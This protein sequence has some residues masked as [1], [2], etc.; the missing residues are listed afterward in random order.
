MYRGRRDVTLGGE[1]VEPGLGG[2]HGLVVGK[3]RIVVGQ[4]EPLERDAVFVATVLHKRSDLAA[5]LGCVLLQD[6]C[7]EVDELA[8]TS[9]PGVYAA[10]DMAHRAA[11]PMPFAAVSW[12][13]ASG[14][15]AGAMLDQDLIG[16]HFELPAAA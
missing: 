2:G 4:G 12:A 15:L 10:G 11:L 7:V 9:V 14:T 13:S 3:K 16:T 1:G 8:R 6:G 5:R